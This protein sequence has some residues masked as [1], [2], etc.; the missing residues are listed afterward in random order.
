MFKIKWDEKSFSDLN[1]ISSIIARRIVKKVK[2]LSNGPFSKDVIKLRSKV[3]LYRLR[4]GD[5]RVIFK[6]YNKDIIIVR[7]GHRK[8]IYKKRL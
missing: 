4:I 8:N 5:Y 1:K 7:V 2:S 6:I 3:D